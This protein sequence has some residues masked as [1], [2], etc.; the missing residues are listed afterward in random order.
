MEQPRLIMIAG[1]RTVLLAPCH[2][3]K[4][5]PAAGEGS[6]GAKQGLEPETP[7]FFFLVGSVERGTSAR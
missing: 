3:R 7:G 4:P 5:V 1:S 2:R 6:L